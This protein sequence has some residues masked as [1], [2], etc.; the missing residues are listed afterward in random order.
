MGEQYDDIVHKMERHESERSK[1]E[2][3]DIFTG[4]AV[5]VKSKKMPEISTGPVS[6]NSRKKPEYIEEDP[7]MKNEIPVEMEEQNEVDTQKQADILTLKQDLDSFSPRTV[8]SHITEVTVE[9][10]LSARPVPIAEDEVQV[11][12]LLA[13]IPASPGPSQTELEPSVYNYE[14]EEEEEEEEIIT[15]ENET[16]SLAETVQL[17]DSLEARLEQTIKAES[18]ELPQTPTSIAAELS[19]DALTKAIS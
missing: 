8:D 12:N 19:E 15:E 5:K 14:N 16:T 1:N 3:H 17:E 4:K 7:D 6:S 2:E 13:P 9:D 18:T 11:P 10:D